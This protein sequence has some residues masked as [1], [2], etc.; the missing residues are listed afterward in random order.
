VPASAAPAPTSTDVLVVGA[1]PAGMECAIVL[2]KRGF[3][4][5]HLVE[6]DEEIGGHLRWLTRL[7]GIGEWAR[8]V[9]W[10]RVQ[11]DRLRN[12]E[13][14]TGTRLSAADVRSYGAELVVLAT[15][16]RWAHDGLNAVTHE[17]I[18]GADA[19]LDHVLTPE[20][21]MA[22]GKR[23]PG[24][25]VC[26][27]D[28]EGYQ[29]GAAVAEQ[30]VSEGFDVELV[31]PFDIV[32]P[33][34]DETLEGPLLRRRIHD[35]G[36]AVR[37]NVTVTLVEPGRLG[38][39][40]EFGDRLELDADAIVLVTQRV[41]DDAVYLEL[42]ADEDT[43]RAEGVEA[44]YRIGDCVSPRHVADAVFD[45][46]RLGREIDSEDPAVPLPHRRELPSPARAAEL[47]GAW[48][49]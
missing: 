44:V 42:T 41:S 17:P 37:R 40:G 2:G 14:L 19:S 24:R 28:A 27:Y 30:L 32:A 15:G 12:V 3:R 22:A 34:C 38:A 7:P 39:E 46:H 25:R 49:A 16:S 21:V 48:R 29:V 4:R 26:V 1:G 45:G 5:V 8:I 31:T 43:L 20:Q 6:A 23:P 13:V 35:A 33:S 36:V 11:L 10:R 47:L 9:N 18:P